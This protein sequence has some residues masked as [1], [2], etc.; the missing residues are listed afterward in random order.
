MTYVTDKRTVDIE[1][2]GEHIVMWS[3]P[4]LPLLK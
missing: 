3:N 2:D 1:T 4:P